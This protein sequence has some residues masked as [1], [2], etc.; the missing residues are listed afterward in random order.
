MDRRQITRFDVRRAQREA[1]IS[2]V[3]ATRVGFR[4]L[5]RVKAQH[6]DLTGGTG[7]ALGVHQ[8]R[9]RAI[10]QQRGQGQAIAARIDNPD[11]NGQITL[12]QPFG[13]ARTD[14][15]IAVQRIA[16]TEH[17]PDHFRLPAGPG[18]QSGGR[19]QENAR[20]KP[21]TDHGSE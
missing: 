7:A 19:R 10:R 6:G 14:S 21:D 3:A 15:I 18:G 11:I 4:P 1:E 8:H 5:R 13:N 2:A 17:A 12:A 20:C 16:E 9:R